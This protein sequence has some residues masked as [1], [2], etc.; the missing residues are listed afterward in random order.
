MD[1]SSTSCAESRILQEQPDLITPLRI[2]QVYK[3]T[4]KIFQPRHIE[5]RNIQDTT[6]DYMRRI[7]Y[8]Q[9]PATLSELG[10]PADARHAWLIIKTLLEPDLWVTFSLLELMPTA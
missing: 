9:M 2:Q 4:G 1:G 10:I 8:H 5:D 7:V 6:K 3:R